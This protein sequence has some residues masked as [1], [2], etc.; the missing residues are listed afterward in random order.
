MI[1]EI[2]GGVFLVMLHKSKRSNAKAYCGWEKLLLCA[3]MLNRQIREFSLLYHLPCY[4]YL[5]TDLAP[6]GGALVG[7]GSG[8]SMHCS[9]ERFYLSSQNELGAGEATIFGF[10]SSSSV[11]CSKERELFGAVSNGD[12]G[13]PFLVEHERKLAIWEFLAL[14]C[15]L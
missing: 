9:K 3:T 1:C 12:E 4:S 11:H 8:F 14:N 5:V 6:F 15:I 2:K 13:S 10:T 7:F